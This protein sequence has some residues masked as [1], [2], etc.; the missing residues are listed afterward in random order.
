MTEFQ[1][2]E[3]VRFDLET[4][5]EH[6]E[7]GATLQRIGVLTNFVLD[8]DFLNV[9]G[10]IGD[11]GLH[12]SLAAQVGPARSKVVRLPEEMYSKR[13]MVAGWYDPA[14]SNRRLGLGLVVGQ[15]DKYG[16]NEGATMSYEHT[17]RCLGM[18]ALAL[19]MLL[20][21]SPE[22]L[23]KFK[24]PGNLVFGSRLLERARGSVGSRI[25]E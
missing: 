21:R 8:G 14:S 24:D 9:R 11:C 12:D 2:P 18:A 19:G 3:H 16:F 25:F 4:F 1:M 6:P 13:G 5:F 23:S 17:G 20:P 7:G 15:I 22:E 10:G